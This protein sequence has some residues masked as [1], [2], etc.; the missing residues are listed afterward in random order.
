MGAVVP[1][2]HNQ[3]SAN[4][5]EQAMEE[6]HHLGASDGRL[7]DAKVE[8]PHRCRATDRRKLGSSAF[9]DEHRRLPYWRPRLR[10]V[11]AVR[12][13]REA[14]LVDEHPYGPFPTG[15]FL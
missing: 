14:V 2:H 4:M 3:V 7:V 9:I 12:G 5:P 15:F 13:Q 10:A 6:R 11:R 8:T 1:E